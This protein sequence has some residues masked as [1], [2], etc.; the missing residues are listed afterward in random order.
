MTTCALCSAPGKLEQSHLIPRF[1]YRGLGAPDGPSRPLLCGDCE[2]RFSLWESRFAREV[3]HPL[4]AG[5]AVPVKYGPWLPRFAASV[6][7]RILENARRENQLA[8]HDPAAIDAC[9]GAWRNFLRDRR[10]D[11]G[12]HHL[13]LVREPGRPSRTIEGE[14]AGHDGA[15]WVCA[16]MGPVALFGLI[17]DDVPGQWTNTRINLE[18]KLKGHAF[19]IPGPYS[20]YLAR[21]V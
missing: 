20:E 10:P 9:L 13:H 5:R 18:G 19:A 3:F 16:G 14:V 4:V 1:V 21:R 11:A 12:G 7:W 15:A 6:C 8:G 17:R 2:D